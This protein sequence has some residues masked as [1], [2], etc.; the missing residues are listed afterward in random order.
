VIDKYALRS[1]EQRDFT[2]EFKFFASR[3]GG[4]GGQNVNK[5]SSK[6]ELRF[7]VDS[8]Q[9]LTDEEKVMIREKLA[10]HI[11]GE[12]F[13]QVVSQEE[14][15][16]LLNKEKTVKKFYNLLKKAFHRPKAR[17]ATQPSASSV[18]KRIAAKKKEGEKK[19]SRR[20]VKNDFKNN[21]N[22]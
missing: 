5:V 22:E 18:E 8:S 2:P 21:L 19:A 10:G 11:N 15:S 9:L 1:V 13:L 4:A 12:G 14:R 16:Q 6:V 3:S 17:K 20:A 7:H